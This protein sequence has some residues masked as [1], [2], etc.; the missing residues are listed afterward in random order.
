MQTHN[1][2]PKS[3][4][5]NNSASDELIFDLSVKNPSLKWNADGNYPYSRKMDVVEYERQKH[6][7][8]IELLKMQ[9]WVERH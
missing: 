9:G 7:L 2:A 8:Q 6:E 5:L 1:V 4:T 3:S